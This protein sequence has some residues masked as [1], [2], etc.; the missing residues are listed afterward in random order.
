MKMDDT[1]KTYIDGKFDIV[2][3][4]LKNIDNHLARQNGTIKTHDDQIQEA[5]QW[6]AKKYQQIDDKFEDYDELAP[7]IRKLEDNQLQSKSVKKFMGLL[8][9]GGI[10]LGAVI[11]ALLTLLGG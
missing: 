7:K 5:L 10:A 4:S 9:T 2:I 8:F 6:R 3:V 11:V 1:T